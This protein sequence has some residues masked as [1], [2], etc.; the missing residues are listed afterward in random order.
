MKVMRVDVMTGTR[1]RAIAASMSCAGNQ[2]ARAA[3]AL[4]AL[5][6]P[7]D[8]ELP[9]DELPDDELPDD[10]PD[11]PLDEPAAGVPEELDDASL[12]DALLESLDEL[13]DD[14][15]SGFALEYRSLY[16]PLPFSVN[17]VRE[18]RRSSAPPHASHSV[19]SGSLMRCWY[20]NSLWQALH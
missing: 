12:D 17:A 16:Q 9:D 4:E 5:P 10:E 6:P 2:V 3:A 13:S 8:D 18:I 11:E 7:D 1:C 20:S 14:F 15:D 19:L